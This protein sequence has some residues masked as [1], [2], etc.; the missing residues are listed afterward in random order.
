MRLERNL[1]DGAQ[2]RLV[3]VSLEL[4]IVAA[5][6]DS[7]P[8]AAREVLTEAQDDL[9]RG[10]AELRELASASTRPSSM[11]VYQR[12]RPADAGTDPCRHHGAA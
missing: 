3:S 12:R 1:H 5:K 10:F 2:Q 6:L 7:D 11:I 9:A 8:R 4:S